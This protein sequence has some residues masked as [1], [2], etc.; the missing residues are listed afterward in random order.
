VEGAW[1]TNGVAA[2]AAAPALEACAGSAPMVCPAVGWSNAVIVTLADDWPPVQGGSLTVDCAPMCGWAVV[3]DGPPAE[4]DQVSLPLDGPTAILQ[5]DMSSPGS[6]S[7][8][9]R[10]PD[11]GEL[12]EL[13]TGLGWRRVGGSAECG[14]PPEATVLVPAP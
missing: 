1:A 6:V 2:T 10:R 7:I 13:D 3:Q 12:A 8:R 4:Q 9:V 14:G 11:E 5:L